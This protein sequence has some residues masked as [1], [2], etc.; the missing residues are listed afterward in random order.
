MDEDYIVLHTKANNKFTFYE[1]HFHGNMPALEGYVTEDFHKFIY[2]IITTNYIND[3]WY[4]RKIGINP[5]FQGGS[6]YNLSDNGW[7]F[8][9]FWTKN[10]KAAQQY[11]DDI[12]KEYHKQLDDNSK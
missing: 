1:K 12:W 4:E 7:I 3:P 11:C 8:I 6:Q 5:F 10:I 9:E 2:Q